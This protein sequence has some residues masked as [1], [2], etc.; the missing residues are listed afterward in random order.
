MAATPFVP[1]IIDKIELKESEILKNAATIKIIPKI[2]SGIC[3]FT[4]IAQ[5]LMISCTRNGGLYIISHHEGVSLISNQIERGIHR[6]QFL[7]VASP[8]LWLL[9]F[10]LADIFTAFNFSACN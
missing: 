10:Q 3:R 2:I 6:L 7:N 9:C 8:R 1:D 5:F 4:W